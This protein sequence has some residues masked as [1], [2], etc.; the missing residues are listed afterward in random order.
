MKKEET[1]PREN[2]IYYRTVCD[3]PLYENIPL[4]EVMTI[5]HELLPDI[6]LS[7]NIF[8]DSDLEDERT[9]RIQQV[10]SIP[11]SDEEYEVRLQNF[12]KIEA[13]REKERK[14]Q[15]ERT[16]KVEL[17]L[18]KNLMK[19]YKDQLPDNNV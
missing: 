9:L 5:L 17:S 8:N 16:Q 7:F 4:S 10:I 3:F 1:L 19:K 15:T 11:E 18:L 12:K 13:Q 14:E 6:K 2:H